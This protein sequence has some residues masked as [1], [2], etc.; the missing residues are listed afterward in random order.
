MAMVVAMISAVPIRLPEN[1]NVN[2]EPDM[3]LVSPSA[4]IHQKGIVLA[5]RKIHRKAAWTN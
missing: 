3:L 1:H 2:G 5:A 4:T